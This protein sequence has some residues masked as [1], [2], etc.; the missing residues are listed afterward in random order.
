MFW[1]NFVRL[2]AENGVS[3]N[4]VAAECGVKSTGT[5]SGWK[6]GAMPSNKTLSK[7]ANRFN[8]SVEILL[9][10]DAFETLEKLRQEGKF[11]FGPL[12][13]EKKPVQANELTKINIADL[14]KGSSGIELKDFDLGLTEAQTTAIDLILNMTDDQL[15]AFIAAAEAFLR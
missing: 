15:K 11:P 2:C 5:V 1:T 4:K 8:V 12:A 10:E 9:K 13:S 7:L 3:P 14:F 6:K